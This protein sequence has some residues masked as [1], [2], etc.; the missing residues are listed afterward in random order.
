LEGNYHAAISE[1]EKAI[2]IKP[3][4]GLLY[5]NLA[6]SYSL[7]GDYENAIQT[8]RK[9][10]KMTDFYPK[11]YNN[12]GLVLFK[13]GQYEQSMETFRK[14]EN[15]AQAYNNLGCIYLQKGEQDKAISY[16]EKAI[17]SNPTYYIIAGENLKKARMYN[18]S[19]SSYPARKKIGEAILLEPNPPVLRQF[20]TK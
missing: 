6:L 13:Y 16:F 9:A 15:E 12:L 18:H 14:A 8:F 10:L 7:K 11:I 4:K 20:M 1:Y 17:E 2:A 5:N 3:D 19:K